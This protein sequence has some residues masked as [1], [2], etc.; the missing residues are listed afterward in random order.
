MEE[1]FNIN[2]FFCFRCMFLAF[3]ELIMQEIGGHVLHHKK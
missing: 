3:Y 2:H 1:R